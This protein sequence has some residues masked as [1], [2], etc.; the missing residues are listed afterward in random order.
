MASRRPADRER[1]AN[2]DHGSYQIS[3]AVTEWLEAAERVRG[4]ERHPM[5][6]DEDFPTRDDTLNIDDITTDIEQQDPEDSVLGVGLMRPPRNT[7]KAPL[8]A[9][10]EL[11]RSSLG[12]ADLFVSGLSYSDVR[13]SSSITQHVQRHSLFHAHRQNGRLPEAYTQPCDIACWHCC[14]SF[15]TPPFCV[16]RDFD[17]AEG[18]YLVYGNF[19]SLAC[20]KM[21]LQENQTYNS[22]YQIMLL[23]RLAK[24]VY[25]VDQIDAAPPRLSLDIFGGPYPIDAFRKQTRAVAIHTP[26]FVSTY[27]VVEERETSYDASSMGVDPAGSVRGLRRPTPAAKPTRAASGAGEPSM[28]AQ[29]IADKEGAPEGNAGGPSVSAATSSEV[30]KGPPASAPARRGAG[31]TVSLTRFMKT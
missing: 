7:S 4:D 5:S 21:Y 13:C 26:P 6:D 10:C 9:A 17:S 3:F 22:A 2:A 31:G 28:F 16:P 25:G 24:T 12:R 11:K 1:R 29:Y 30:A 20:A 23:Y 27:M 18:C 8:P 15:S 19:C 14:H